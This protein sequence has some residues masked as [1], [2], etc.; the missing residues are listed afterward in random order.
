MALFCISYDLVKGKDYP[1]LWAEL[2]R[3]GGHKALESFYLVD[4]NSTVIEVRD[5]LKSFVDD[6]D[7]LMVIEFSK[8]PHFIKAKAGTNDWIAKHFP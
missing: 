7:K 2:D 6:D 3:M 5:H 8:K 1:A 4:L